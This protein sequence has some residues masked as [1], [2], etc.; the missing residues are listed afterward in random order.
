MKIFDFFKPKPKPR[1][2]V[3]ISVL[4]KPRGSAFFNCSTQVLEKLAQIQGHESKFYEVPLFND[5]SLL[6]E[7][8]RK[9]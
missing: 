7:F 2:I 8:D 9:P 3:N 4:N 6:I 1:Y 5:M